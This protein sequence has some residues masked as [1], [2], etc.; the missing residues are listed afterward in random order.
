MRPGF[1]SNGEPRTQQSDKALSNPPTGLRDDDAGLGPSDATSSMGAAPR[2]WSSSRPA[3]GF[4]GGP[5]PSHSDRPP[6]S[7]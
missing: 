5:A 4:M 1:V 3:N 2:A 7:G 6:L